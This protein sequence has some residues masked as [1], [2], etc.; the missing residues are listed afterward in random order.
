MS[1]NV[2]RTRGTARD[3]LLAAA[4]DLFYVNG[5]N[6]TGVEALAT[7]AGVTKATLYNNFRS[8]DEV[9][10]AYLREKLSATKAALDAHDDP[11]APPPERVAVVFDS[12]AADIDAGRFQGCPFAKAA[13]EVPA[14]TAAM[15]VVREHHDTVVGHLTGITAD[16]RA[17]ETIT[18]LYDGAIV[19]AKATGDVAPVVHAR[20]AALDLLP[21]R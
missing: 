19:A 7:A 21:R 6:T 14:N 12:L 16:P 8:K 5:I 3:R 1:E 13:V 17:A 2:S 10:V 18:M 4:R 11:S 9:V 20:D 15:T